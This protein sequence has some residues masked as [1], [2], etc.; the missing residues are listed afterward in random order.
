[1]ICCTGNVHSERLG[2]YPYNR[3]AVTK[4]HNFTQAVRQACASVPQL[5]SL[6]VLQEMF[7]NMNACAACVHM[8]HVTL[9]SCL[10]TAQAQARTFH[11]PV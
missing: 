9:T 3:A 1:M 8:R 2:C 10:A 5:Q 6:R 11:I 7:M 4:L